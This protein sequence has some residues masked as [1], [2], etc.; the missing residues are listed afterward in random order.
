MITH[1]VFF[2]F[3]PENRSEHI[4]EAKRRIAAMEGQIPTLRSI[5][6]GENF[7]DEARAM[8]LALTAR[9]D[10]RDGLAAYAVHPVHRAVIAYI[11]TVVAYTRVVDYAS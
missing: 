2:A 3:K 4:A 5:E 11:Q 6:L 9:F 1:I 8:D 7:S 10:D